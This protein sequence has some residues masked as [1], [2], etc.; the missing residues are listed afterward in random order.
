M[1][2]ASLR[3]E[4]TL[5]GLTEEKCDVSPF[6]QF[7][8]WF[9][10]ARQAGIEEPNAMTLATVSPEG[11]P[12]ARILLL[13]HFDEQGFVFFTNYKSHKG[14]DL[15]HNPKASLLFFW[16]ELQRQV[17]IQGFVHKITR[18]QSAEYFFSR[19][20]ESRIGAWASEQS[21][22]IESR[23]LLEKNYARLKNEFGEEIPLPDFWGGYCLNPIYFEFW[24]GRESRLHDRITYSKENNEWSRKRISP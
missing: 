9:S 15:E 7:S 24:Q 18:E 3:K 23:E 19:P 16:H 13:K 20:L 8:L 14:N 5:G 12:S 21:T 4:Y 2:L 10:E 6:K 11:M 1:N 17:R 22:V